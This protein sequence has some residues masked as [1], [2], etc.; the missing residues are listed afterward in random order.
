LTAEVNTL[1]FKLNNLEECIKMRDLELSKLHSTKME[2]ITILHK[3]FEDQIE[4]KNKYIQDITDTASQTSSKLNNIERELVDLKLIVENKNEEVKN[5]S[6][7]V[8]GKF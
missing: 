1:R 8:S 6:D 2:E 3:Q 4:N 5:L 7:R